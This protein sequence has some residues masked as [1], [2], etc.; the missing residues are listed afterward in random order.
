MKNISILGSTG[1]I[2]TQTL[3][4]VAANPSKLKIVALAANSNDRLMEAQIEAF[5]PLVAAL[6]DEKAA[7]RL[8]SRYRGKTKILS[9]PDGVQAIATHEFM[10]IADSGEAEIV[11]CPECAY[12]ANVEKTELFPI[13]VSSEEMLPRQEVVTPECKTIAAVCEFLQIPIEKSVK[14]VAYTSSKG[15]ILCF[16]RGDHGEKVPDIDLNFSGEYQPQAHKY[17]E[18]LFGRDNVFRA[19]T[20]GTIAAKTAYG[21]VKKYFDGKGQHVSIG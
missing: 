2:G 17:T 6:S 13:E 16:V 11:F 18:E 9:G 14:A 19:G 1:S 10:A 4:V 3:D 21:Y 8:R 20:L 12:A 7:Q 15:L 5:N